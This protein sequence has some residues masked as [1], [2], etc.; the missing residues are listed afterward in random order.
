MV[1]E[2]SDGLTTDTAT[3]TIG[4]VNVNQAAVIV[5]DISGNATEDRG[6]SG[7]LTITD[8]DG[9][10]EAAFQAEFIRGTFGQI[11]IQ[12]DGNW[13]YTPFT[14]PV[15]QAIRAGETVSDTF[16]LTSVD[17]TPWISPF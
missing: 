2:A 11:G 12:A 15:T 10:D 1:F 17:G 3:L 5:G 14:T 16:T 9:A 8:A 4:V 13:R 6:V 7:L